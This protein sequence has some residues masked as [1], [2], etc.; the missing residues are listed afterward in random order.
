MLTMTA[1]LLAQTDPLETA[2]AVGGLPTSA[3]LALVCVGLI[4]LYRETKA[5]LKAALAANDALDAARVD[6]LKE[7]IRDLGGQHKEAA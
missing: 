3:V 4:W 6:D 2:K 1:M 5:D 7:T